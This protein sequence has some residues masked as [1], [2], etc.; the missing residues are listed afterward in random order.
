MTVPPLH[1]CTPLSG[2]PTASLVPVLRRIW[3][4]RLGLLA[5][6]LSK[7]VSFAA[8]PEIAIE[9]VPGKELGSGV[10]VWGDNRFGQTAV[11]AAAQ[12]GVQAIVAGDSHTVALK[13]DGTVVAWGRGS[14]GQTNV[15]EGLSEVQ[16]IAAGFNHTVALKSNGT[17]VMWGSNGN[18]Q[19]RIPSAARRDVQA[20]A[21]AYNRTVALKRDG[22]VV[23]W[24]LDDLGQTTVPIEAKTDAIA[25]TAGDA[26]TVVLKSDSSLVAWGWGIHGQTNIPEA[27]QTGVLAIAAG[28]LHAVALKSDGSLV[29]WGRSFD[30][31]TTVPDGLTGVRALAAGGYHTVAL[32]SDGTVVAWGRNFEGQTT[33]PAGLSSV[34]AIA[35]GFAHTAALRSSTVVFETQRVSVIGT[36]KT[37]TIRN[38]GDAALHISSVSVVGGNVDDFSVTSALLLT[39]VPAISGATTFTVAFSPTA[40]GFR[41]ATL[42]V[43]SDDA[44]ESITDIALTGLAT[45][46]PPGDVPPVETPETPLAAANDAGFT[47]GAKAI[48]IDVLANDPGV[49][50]STA[51]ITFPTMPRHGTVQL[52]GGKV[53]YIPDGALPL[54]GDTFTYHFDD[55]LGGTGDGTVPID[56]FASIAGDYDGLIVADPAISGAE[57]HQQSGHLRVTLSKT[58]VYTGAL[59][60]GGAKVEV[61]GQSAER[62]FAIMHRLDGEGNSVRNIA[63]RA[64]PITLSLHFDA[65]TQTFTGTASAAENGTAFTS[66]L[67]LARRT[68]APALAGKYALQIQPE[69]IPAAPDGSSLSHVRI[70]R[71]GNVLVTG[72]LPD[73]APFASSTLLHADKSFPL[74]AILYGGKVTTRGSLSGRVQFPGETARITPAGDT[75]EWFKPVRA[76]D[77][78]FPQGFAISSSASFV[79]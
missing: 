51:T 75:L 73:G 39:E 14:E 71:N 59:I 9:Q 68:A 7:S 58:G 29:A 24:G 63:R 13:N 67:T 28:N 52:I 74:Y 60:V 40:P 78:L 4:S 30:G 33:V 65:E 69:A 16:A 70:A 41:T 76:R 8:G 23:A 48:E 35:A 15:P 61:P 77:K 1:V 64:S 12:T 34:V 36:A 21:A 43:L 2:P 50:R 20:I 47:T 31:Q 19:I 37:F 10:I 26:H 6:L 46:P 42:R 66:T 54:A 25:I 62:R 72:R 27:A 18:G 53:R 55:G 49:N 57:R 79:E 38:T 5:V 44:D 22:T 45:A 32:K 17:I 11:P 56:N 3:S